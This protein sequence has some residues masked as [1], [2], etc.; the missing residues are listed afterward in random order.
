MLATAAPCVTGGLR[1]RLLSIDPD[2]DLAIDSDM[3]RFDEKWDMKAGMGCPV[4]AK[5][6]MRVWP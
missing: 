4:M 2:L 6:T 5:G 3:K 1:E